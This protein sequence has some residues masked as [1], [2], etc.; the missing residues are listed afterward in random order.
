MAELDF[1]CRPR[2]NDPFL[3]Q[4]IIESVEVRDVMEPP[5]IQIR[6]LSC[7]SAYR[8]GLRV[9]KRGTLKQPS[10]AAVCHGWAVLRNND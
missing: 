1:Q 6:R 7:E 9:G 10:Y 4:T 8:R 2:Y 3:L 5:K